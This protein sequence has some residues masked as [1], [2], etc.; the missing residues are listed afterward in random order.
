MSKRTTV[1]KAE[2]KRHI[3][4]VQDCGLPVKRVEIEGNKISVFTEDSDSLS[5]L[6]RWEAESGHGEDIRH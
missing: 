5:D 1:T 4:A 3:E 2:I 6:D